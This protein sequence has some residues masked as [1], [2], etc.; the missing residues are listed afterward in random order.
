MRL[1]ALPQNTKQNAQKNVEWSAVFKN[2]CLTLETRK[3]IGDTVK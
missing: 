1:V 2:A 3:E